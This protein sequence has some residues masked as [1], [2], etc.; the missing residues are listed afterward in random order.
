MNTSCAFGKEKKSAERAEVI[1]ATALKLFVAEGYGSVSLRRIADISGV[2]V[3][4]LYNHIDGKQQ[5]LFELI[6]E[7]EQNLLAALKIV[8]NKADKPVA[9]MSAYV[10]QYFIHA[11]LNKELHLLAVREKRCLDEGDA[12]RLKSLL[13]DH[14]RLLHG[15]LDRGCQAGVFKIQN[16]DFAT[17][18]IWSLLDGM[19][20]SIATHQ[21]DASVSA[22]QLKVFVIRLLGAD[23]L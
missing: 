7:A 2:Q 18:A 16:S 17:K 15:V 21:S 22:D 10:E 20:G 23:A 8:V 12:S 11:S 3:G 14:E 19:L 4:S 1:R 6:Y 9:Q 13:L 5:L